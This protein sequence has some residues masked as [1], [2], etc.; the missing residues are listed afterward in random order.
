MTA[1][2][3][4]RLLVVDD[5]PLIR[6][7]IVGLVADQPDMQVV[8]EATNGRE[9][10]EQYRL[11]RPSITLMDLQMPE[12]A[13]IDAVLAIRNEFPDAAFIVLTTYAGDAHVF[14]ALQAGA[15]GYLL[16]N[17]LHKEL[18][19]SVRAVHAGK[20]ALSAQ[21]SIELAE[22]ALRDALTPS[23]IAVLRFVAEGNSNKQIA[24]RLGLTE[25]TIKNRIKSILSKL[26][27][28]DRT[29]AAMIAIRRGVIEI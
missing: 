1:S 28:E 17:T 16:K 25:D 19:D 27:A 4:I 20:K 23:E 13:G 29:H 3:L 10:I 12:L 26:R 9:A 18:L 14:R 6:R 21:L 2:E 11:H 7:G 24:H 22:N 15:R 5:H 8:A